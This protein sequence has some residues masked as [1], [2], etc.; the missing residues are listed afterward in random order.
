[1][2]GCGYL[3]G[4]IIIFDWRDCEKPRKSIVGLQAEICIWG[5]T[6]DNHSVDM[7]TSEK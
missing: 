3:M 5:L 1:M 2:E 6:R 7:V 4:T